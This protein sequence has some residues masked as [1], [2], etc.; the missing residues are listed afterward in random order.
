VYKNIKL[1][2]PFGSTKAAEQFLK[3]KLKALTGNPAAPALFFYHYIPK[4]ASCQRKE[5]DFSKKYKP[6]LFSNS[7]RIIDIAAQIM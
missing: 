3:Q 4:A 6:F 5:R 2:A 7:T 1:F